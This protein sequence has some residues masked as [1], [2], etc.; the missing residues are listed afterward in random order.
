MDGVSKPI[1]QGPRR[2][3]VK[4]QPGKHW[5]DLLPCLLNDCIHPADHALHGINVC[6][7]PKCR[8]ENQRRHENNVVRLLSSAKGSHL[9]CWSPLESHAAWLLPAACIYKQWICALHMLCSACSST[10]DLYS[11]ASCHCRMFTCSICLPHRNLLARG[12]K[13]DIR[14]LDNC[15]CMHQITVTMHDN[16]YTFQHYFQMCEV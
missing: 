13:S 8:K 9:L 3:L 2:S 6:N 11:A 12:A 5:L 1:R 4:E 10:L 15:N 16:V 7:L 14:H